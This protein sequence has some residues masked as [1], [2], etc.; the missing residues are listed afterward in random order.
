MKASIVKGDVLDLACG[1]L[2]VGVFKDSLTP[3][4]QALDKASGGLVSKWMESGDIHGCVGKCAEFF[5]F[6][7]AKAERVIFVGLG[8]K[9]KAREL[10][11]ILKLGLE[12]AYL[13][14]EVVITCL[15]WLPDEIPEWIAQTAGRIACN[16]FDRPRNYKTK[17]IDWKKPKKIELFVPDGNED[18]ETAFLEGFTVGEG[19]RRTKEYGDMPANICTPKFMAQECMQLGEEFG[20]DVSVYD[21]KA[22]EKLGMGCLLGVARGSHQPAR[23][24]IMEYHGGKKGEAPVA[25]IGK[26][27]TFDSGGISLKPG[28]GMD[29][30]KY[31]MCGAAS[32]IGAITTAAEL[33]LKVNIVA[34]LGFTENMPGS[35]ATKPGDILKSYSGKTV[36]ILNTDAEGRLVLCDLLSFVK[37]KFKPKCMVDAAT[38]TGA[39]IIALGNDISGLFA[40]DEEM[41]V[42]MLMAGD[43]SLD[44]CWRLPL[45]ISF[46]KSLRSNFADLA[47]ISDGRGAGSSTAAAFLEEF[48]S[49]TPWA[50]LDIAGTAW[51]S[52]KEKG[53]T[54]RPVPLL[55][56]FLK[57]LDIE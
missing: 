38:L 54:G 34:A 36:E 22:L 17:D 16:A 4:A 6:P 56:S 15:E 20:L 55:I 21:E 39:C 57:D 5:G 50:H 45:D 13:G 2:I 37:D 8:K 23:M 14:K 44:P 11:R 28:K 31:D 30:M 19:V 47:N 41:A 26:G 48:V 1:A 7:G 29:E 12:K 9:G 27:L 43:A 24:V 32:M 33:K 3:S 53:A 52:G 10:P 25:L 35:A 46:N 49:D 18:I 40:N 51:K 42:S